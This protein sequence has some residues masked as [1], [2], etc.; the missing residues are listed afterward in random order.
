MTTGI[1]LLAA[2]IT[3]ET[4][5]T[6][7]TKTVE[8]VDVPKT[9]GTV[10]FV[11]PKEKI[12]ANVKSVRVLPEFAKARYGEDGWLMAADGTRGFFVPRESNIR[13]LRTAS[14]QI[15]PLYGMKTPRTTFVALATGMK[16]HAG[17]LYAASNGWYSVAFDFHEDM[18][19]VYEDISVLYRVFDDPKAD[20]NDMAHWYRDYQRANGRLTPL[21]ERAAAHP[22]LAYATQCPEV[23]IRQAWKPVPAT[24]NRQVPEN[25]PKIT[26]YVTF[27]RVTELANRVHAAGVK[28]AEFCLVGWNKGGHDGAYPQLFPVEPTLGG[29]ESLRAC[30]RDVQALGYK[31]VAHV[32]HNDAYMI[33]DSFDLEFVTEKDSEGRVVR[34]TQTWG[35]GGM[36]KMC[37][38]RAYEKFA[39]RDAARLSALGFDGLFYLDVLTCHVLGSCRDPRHPLTRAGMVKWFNAI[40]DLYGETFGG[41]ASEGACDAYAGHFD[42]VLTASWSDPFPTPESELPPEKRAARRRSFFSDHVPFWE[43]VYHGYLL[44]TP[45]RNIMNAT[46]NPDPRFQLKLAEYDGRPTFYVHS[47]FQTKP[48]ASMGARDLRADTDDELDFSVECIRRG[49]EEY[50]RRSDLQF[51]FMEHHEK[52]AEGVFKTT[53]SNGAKTCVNYCAEAKT[54][55]GVT[56]PAMD[57][58]VVR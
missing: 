58:V 40:L 57:Y 25:E 24:V 42:S 35:G 39:I 32:N 53:F 18:Y 47:R 13:K 6:D 10:R 3:V 46:A 2:I 17:V 44:Y 37:P 34:P 22:Q 29:E 16:Y 11:W 21:K 1:A 36:F 33:A 31:I 27:K 15:T 54:V 55:D 48:N 45:F 52:V 26:P 28:G 19:D 5:L 49:A 23:R 12:P 14:H 30:I 7:G 51:A 56:V 41:V 8:T 38:Q 20:Y 50:A 9:D 4:A 43:L